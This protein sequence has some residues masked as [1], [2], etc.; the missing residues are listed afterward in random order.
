[1]TDKDLIAW[2]DVET[3]GLS[4]SNSSLLEIAVLITDTDLNL[5]D[6]AGYH[7]TIRYS[8]EEVESLK[9]E[10][11]PFVVEMHT[12][13]GLWSR[14]PEGK[15]LEVVEEEVLAYIKQFAPRPQQARVGGNSVRL[16]LNFL[17]A[18]LPSVARHL[19]YRFFDV[20]SLATAALWWLGSEPDK[21]ESDHTAKGDILAS[22]EQARALRAQFGI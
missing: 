5:L 20:T 21:P 6:D 22:L 2:I 11:V 9:S 7:G 1:M 15:P 8:R 12:K 18:F 3:T 17:D 10:T 14:L 16:D 13:N 4:P 19:H